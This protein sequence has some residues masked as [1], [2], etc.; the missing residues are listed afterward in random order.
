MRITKEYLNKIIKEEVRRLQEQEFDYGAE[1]RAAAKG[2]PPNPANPINRQAS[3]TPGNPQDMDKAKRILTDR[4]SEIQAAKNFIELENIV[5]K[6][7]TAYTNALVALLASLTGRGAAKKLFSNPPND[8]ILFLRNFTNAG[9][10]RSKVHQLIKTTVN[11][12]EAQSI[13]Q[14]NVLTPATAKGSSV[15]FTEE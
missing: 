9:G 2:R 8:Y 7:N 14:T 15:E 11:S 5:R 13:A 3:A 4:S 10:L 6:T 12:S 1:M